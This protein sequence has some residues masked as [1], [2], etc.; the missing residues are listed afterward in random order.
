MWR[1]RA[2]KELRKIDAADQNR[3]L[4]YLRQR[5]AEGDDPRRFGKALTGDLIG[6]WSYRIG[7]YRL[8]CQLQDAK[9][10]VLVIAVG[11][12]KHIYR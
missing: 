2:A 8:V 9:A 11:H 6:L 10:T 12:R 7:T 1:D 4:K 5:I 3:I